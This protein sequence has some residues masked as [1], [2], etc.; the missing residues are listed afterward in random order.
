MKSKLSGDVNSDMFAG[1]KK[2]GSA[3]FELATLGIVHP[4]L[5]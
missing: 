3:G 1:R 4:L 5:Y 2:V